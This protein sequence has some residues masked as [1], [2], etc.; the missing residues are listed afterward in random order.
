[1]LITGLRTQRFRVT[2]GQNHHF[3]IPN[4]AQNLS[5]QPPLSAHSDTNS[6]LFSMKHNTRFLH[7]NSRCRKKIHK[8]FYTVDSVG[9]LS[10]Q[11]CT[12]V[13]IHFF[14]LLDL[15][16]Y[17]GRVP[18]SVCVSVCVSSDS[19]PI[20]AIIDLRCQWTDQTQICWRGR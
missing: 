7:Y 13:L 15:I 16:S 17:M 5:N 14:F 6:Q 19:C 2:G 10:Q 18:D 12:C 8:L 11:F 9:I 20:T 3:W 1:M 4:P